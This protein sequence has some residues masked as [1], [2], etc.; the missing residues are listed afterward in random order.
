MTMVKE[1]FLNIGTNRSAGGTGL[2]GPHHD[3][4][5]EKEEHLV[6]PHV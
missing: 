4:N 2:S 6:F 1:K 5:E 3:D